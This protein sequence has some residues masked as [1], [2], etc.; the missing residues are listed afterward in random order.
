MNWKTLL[1]VTALLEAAA[2]GA[3]LDHYFTVGWGLHPLIVG[4]GLA[5]LSLIVVALANEE[6]WVTE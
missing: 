1:H 2:L 6:S 5:L 3:L 4:L